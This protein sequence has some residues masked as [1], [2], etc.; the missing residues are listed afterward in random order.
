MLDVYYVNGSMKTSTFA[1]DVKRGLTAERKYLLPK[2]SIR[3]SDPIKAQ[4]IL[5]ESLSLDEC[6]AKGDEV[7]IVLKNKEDVSKIGA[8]LLTAGIALMEMRVLGTM[9]EV[10]LRMRQKPEADA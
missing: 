9:E 4:K 5:S 1:G 7:I 8:L 3:V 6:I 10:F 2:Y